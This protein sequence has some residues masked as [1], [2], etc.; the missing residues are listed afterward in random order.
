MK[1]K[2][3]LILLLLGLITAFG[4]YS[5]RNLEFDTEVSGYNLGTDKDLKEYEEL[6]K[7][8]TT[9]ESNELVIVLEKKNGWKSFEDFNLLSDVLSFWSE[10]EEIESALSITNL[11]Y[12][13]K[14]LLFVKKEPFINLDNKAAFEKRMSKIDAYKDIT[15]KFISADKRYVLLHLKGKTKDGI[16]MDS[17]AEFKKSEFAK[18]GIQAH[19]LQY[20][21]IQQ[22]MKQLMQNDAVLLAL[23][24]LLLILFSFFILTKSFKG[25]VLIGGVIASNLAATL[26]FMMAMDIAFSA[27]MIT[28]PCIVIVLSF[29]DIM[30]LMYHQ[31][32]LATDAKDNKELRVKILKRVKTPMLFTS[33]TNIIGF[34]VFL[35]LSENDHLF[36][37]SLVAIAGVLIAYLNSRFVVIHLLTKENIM[38]KRSNLSFLNDVHNRIKNGVRKQRKWVQFGL[39]AAMAGIL[40]CVVSL[41]KIDTSDY[42]MGTKGSAET[43][44]IEI[45]RKE[46]FGSKRLEVAIHV[47]DQDFWTSTRLKKVENLEKEISKIYDPLFIN[48]PTLL[49]KRYNRF[50]RNGQSG[51]FVVP[52]YFSK[53]TKKDLNRFK[54]F[55]G[56]DGI[57]SEDNKTAKIVFGCGN[58][59]LSK[60]MEQNAQ[61][62]TL[63]AK[64]SD[65]EMRFELT[66]R[67]YISDRGSYSFTVKILIGIGIGILFASLLTFLFMKSIRE[68]IGLIIV[69]LLPVLATLAIMLW[70]GIAI[71]PLTLFFLSILVGICID[72]S[73]YII[74]QEDKSNSDLHIFPVFVT[75]IVLAVGFIALGFSNF[76]WVRP[77]AW[78]FLV[79]IALAYV[80]DLFILPLFFNR[81][82]NFDE[83]G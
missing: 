53:E 13:R 44:A 12:P 51:A 54:Q 66:G 16:S 11:R 39:V 33:L 49:A 50:K 21:V 7:K 48:S 82:V 5:S 65:D 23:I 14:G 63:L 76:E 26:L 32:Q 31:K 1:N 29:T 73:I 18:S 19:Y 20:D 75:S 36:N 37:L 62:E 27:H 68:S 25:L 17:M 3:I 77:F 79:G 64:Y 61:L 55:L 57:L 6:Q 83:R 38:I 42:A 30:H 56:G 4:F 70:V 52:N 60:S 45:L 24:S 59:P 74:T 71:T 40:F 2:S 58:T 35:I 34:V 22:G 67:A 81:N 78:I 15:K 72:D 28:I 9:N 46:F 8:F 43:E 69:N 80:M 41:F 10:R 47:K